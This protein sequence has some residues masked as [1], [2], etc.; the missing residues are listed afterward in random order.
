MPK[1][2]SGLTNEKVYVIFLGKNGNTI[3]QEPPS[4]KEASYGPILFSR[5]LNSGLTWD[6]P[7][8]IPLIDASNYQGFSGGA[9]SIMARG[10]TVAISYGNT[11][12]DI[13][14]LKSTDAGQTWTKTIVQLHPHPRYNINADSI[15]DFNQDGIADTILSNSGDSKVLIDNEGMCH[16]WFSAFSYVNDTT[17]DSL[18]TGFYTTD[19]LY[20]WNETMP[21]N[22]GYVAIA[23]TQDFNGNGVINYPPNPTTSCDSLFP[24]GFYGGG[25]TEKPS[26]GIDAS[27]RIYLAYQAL[28]EEADITNFNALHK[29][30]FMM[31]LDK[32]GGVYQSGNWTYPY[33]IVPG[34]AVGGYGE[35]QEAVFASVT[36]IVAGS[37]VNVLY[38]R[39]D[40][41]GHSFDTC[42]NQHNLGNSSDIV[43]ASIDAIVVSTKSIAGNEISINNIF[44]NP[45]ES[46]TSISIGLKKSDELSIDIFDITGRIVMHESVGKVGPA[47]MDIPFNVSGLVPG[48]YTCTISSGG[49]RS[50]RKLLISRQ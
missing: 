13:G 23:A 11:F 19:N 12:T 29:H 36:P 6:P 40:A 34:M 38:Q 35:F 37:K 21:Q 47:T 24:F 30:I 4:T 1:A 43:I 10:D 48:I 14:L 32:T 27:G 49:E 31:T 33:S 15:S 16:V 44:P 5:S 18:Y 39:D 20:Y 7:V 8:L 3:N 17:G 50:A 2:C 41:P 45:S 28:N 22:N 26:A 42:F 9:Y 46:V 25:L